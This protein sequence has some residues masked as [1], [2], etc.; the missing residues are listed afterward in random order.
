VTTRPTAPRIPS[1]LAAVCGAVLWVLVPQTACAVQV[2]APDFANSSEHGADFAKPNVLR[3]SRMLVILSPSYD[4][5][6]DSVTQTAQ[7][8]A[9]LV[10][11]GAVS[12]SYPQ[13]GRQPIT[14][15]GKGSAKAYFGILSGQADY[16]AHLGPSN[17]DLQ[18]IVEFIDLLTVGGASG[19][20]PVKLDVALDANG[21]VTGFVAPENAAVGFRSFANAF[22]NAQLYVWGFTVIPRRGQSFEALDYQQA[23]FTPTATTLAQ[24]HTVVVRPGEKYWVAGRMEIRIRSNATGLLEFTPTQTVQALADFTHTVRV[25]VNAN[26]ETP[27]ASYSMA[28]GV[29]LRTGATTTTTT[30]LAT[31]PG[32]TTTTTTTPPPSCDTPR[33]IVDEALSGPACSGEAVPANVSAKLHQATSLIEQ[34]GSV[35]AKKARKLL[36]RAKATLRAAK[37]NATRA[38]KGKHAKISSECAAALSA[39]AD[40]SPH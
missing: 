22:A 18:L 15:D 5:D 39:A 11:E 30:T 19:G 32:S 17:G 13:A 2:T 35:P 20:A 36:K 24:P 40:V 34:A 28:S 29:D 3:A 21:T 14:A 4:V 37:T 6:Q 8:Q 38:A 33:C 7:F 16:E 1:A 25:L 31:G 9:P 23:D 27:A 10:T 26:P 12:I